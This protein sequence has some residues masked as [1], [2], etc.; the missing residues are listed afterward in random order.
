M[1]KENKNNISPLSEKS[2]RQ[3]A[4]LEKYH[5]IDYEKRTIDLEL[6]YNKISDIL[7]SDVSTK[8][9]PKFKREILQRASEVIDGFPIDF[10]VNLKL[11]IDD[12]E[13]YKTDEVMESFKDS[14]EMFHY[15]VYRE[16]NRNWILASIFTVIAA[17]LLFFRIFAAKN[18]MIEEN[19]VVYEI[20]DIIA[21]VFL[22]EAVTIIFLSPS[23]LKE[24]SFKLARRLLSIS[25]LNKNDEIISYTSHE[26]LT[27]NWIDDSQKEST[28]RLVLL[29]SGAAC[30]AT[31]VVNLVSVFK[32]LYEFL[33]SEMFT[34]GPLLVAI[35]VVSMLIK[36]F[37]AILFIIGGI[38]A[39]STFS[40]RGPFKKFV[41]ILA[42]TF[43]VLDT[44]LLALIIGSA[45]I[46]YQLSQKFDIANLL[47]GIMSQL[48]TI[49][50][51]VSYLIVKSSNKKSSNQDD[52]V[53]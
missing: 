36:F 10:K 44:F 3:L 28:G 21:W 53:R 11:K 32:D 5:D 41:P 46:E 22:W 48:V 51:F 35:S 17:L 14:L 27:L 42:Y 47:Q 9:Y 26:D 18:S 30:F 34:F 19:G 7:E 8:N 12:L 25:L 40:D 33:S 16:K 1:K 23:E 4:I 6:H 50:Y 2:K 52:I 37:L 38:G 43:I 24:I 15:A 29:I 13:G 49:L 20:L 31:G 39:I 45:V